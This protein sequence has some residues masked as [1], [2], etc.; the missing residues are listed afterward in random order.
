MISRLAVWR[1]KVANRLLLANSNNV[2]R[3]SDFQ[4]LQDP[5]CRTTAQD[6]KSSD[7]SECTTLLSFSSYMLFTNLDK[8][9]IKPKYNKKNSDLAYKITFLKNS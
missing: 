3:S 6:T 8:V 9:D 1:K 2:A 7:F 4:G 5:S